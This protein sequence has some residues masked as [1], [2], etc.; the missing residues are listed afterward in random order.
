MPYHQPVT[1]SWSVPGHLGEQLGAGHGGGGQ[2]LVEAR[3]EDHAFA[4]QVVGGAAEL[5]VETAEGRALVA[6]HEGGGVEPAAAVEPPLVE[7]DPH[8]GL[9]AGHERPSRSVGPGTA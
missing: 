5:E 7:D 8:Q 9:D 1:P 3:A 6:A 2:L 4:G